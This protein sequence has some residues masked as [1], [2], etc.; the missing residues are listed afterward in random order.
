MTGKDCDSEEI[1]VVS[2]K[3]GLHVVNVMQKHETADL[4]VNI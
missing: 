2:R 4:V 1:K 3:R